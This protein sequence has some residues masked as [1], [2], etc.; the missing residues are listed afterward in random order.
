MFF[1]FP[2]D[3]DSEYARAAK[4]QRNSTMNAGVYNDLTATPIVKKPLDLHK[5]SSEMESLNRADDEE[6]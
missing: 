2:R 1:L 5:D 4:V 3:R 6:V